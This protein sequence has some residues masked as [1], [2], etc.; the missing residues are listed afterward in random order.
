MYHF[1]LAFLIFFRYVARC[2]I[3]GSYGSSIF[4][5]LR[6]L[7][8]VFHNSCTNL[9]SLQQCTSVPFSTYPCLYLLLVFFLMTAILTDVKQHLIVVLICIFLMISSVE[10]LFMCLLAICIS[11][12]EN[13]LFSSS[14]HF[15]AE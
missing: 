14:A 10:H 13:C 2:K 12:L 11:S 6:N 9:L 7:H 15:L 5:F 4:S 8:T 3:A 1:K